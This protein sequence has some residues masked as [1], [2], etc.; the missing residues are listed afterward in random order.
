MEG[1]EKPVDGESEDQRRER[2][3]KAAAY[4]LP[5]FDGTMSDTDRRFIRDAL[6]ETRPK[7]TWRD[8]QPLFA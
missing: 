3:A 4:E 5:P 6:R 2:L 7:E 8:R 1:W